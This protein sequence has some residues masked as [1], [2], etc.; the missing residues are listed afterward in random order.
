MKDKDS[1]IASLEENTTNLT[2]E[3]EEL[4]TEKSYRLQAKKDKLAGE[5]LK[6]GVRSYC[7]KFFQVIQD[8]IGVPSLVL[9]WLTRWL[10]LLKMNLNP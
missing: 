1:S 5:S 9:V 3:I 2:L 8:M 6:K 7:H 4:R 10:T